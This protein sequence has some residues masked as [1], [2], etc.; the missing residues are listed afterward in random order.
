MF[1]TVQ[2]VLDGV[3]ASVLV[4]TP[5][6]RGFNLGQEL[7]IF[8]GNQ[9]SQHFG[10]D[11]RPSGPCR[12]ALLLVSL[13]IQSKHEQRQLLRKTKFIISFAQFLLLCH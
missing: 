10:E 3:M 7:W 13:I 9:N 8:K 4:I 1:S 2:V 12:K 6:F 5:K 11:V